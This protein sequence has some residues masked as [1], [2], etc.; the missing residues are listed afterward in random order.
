MGLQLLAFTQLNF[1]RQF[2]VVSFLILLTGMLIIAM[3]VEQQI[4]R[5]VINRTA[6]VTALY[7][8]SFITQYLQDLARTEQLGMQQLEQ[9]NLLLTDTPLG[10]RIVAFKI[11]RRDGTILYSTKDR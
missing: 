1:A 3:W 7:V 2:L 8:D 10:E 5:G 11:W 6:A 4:E 9:L